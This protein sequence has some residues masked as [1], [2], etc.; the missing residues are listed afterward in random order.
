M[1]LVHDSVSRR[2][3]A[4][5]IM[6]KSCLHSTL[7]YLLNTKDWR[8]KRGL[9]GLNRVSLF[10]AYPSA[11]DG[12]TQR[13]LRIYLRITTQKRVRSIALCGALLAVACG[14]GALLL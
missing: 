6:C 4:G 9:S 3:A 10:V 14:D 12:K 13:S 11:V 5:N 7:I 1:S 8:V 2:I